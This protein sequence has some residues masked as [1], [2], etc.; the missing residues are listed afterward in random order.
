MINVNTGLCD[1]CGICAAVCPLGVLSITAGA[2]VAPED[3]KARCV[4]CGHCEAVC[5]RG[6]INITGQ[7][8]ADAPH[9]QS[10]RGVSA[11]MIR[12]YFLSRRSIRKYKPEAVSKEAL[13]NVLDI[14]RYAPSAVNAQPVKWV[15]LYDAAKLNEITKAV[16][17]WMESAVSAKH[18]LAEPLNFRGLIIGWKKGLDPITRHAPHVIV[19]CG[20]KDD[21]RAPADATIALTHLELLA[22]AFGLGACWAGYFQIAASQSAEVRRAIGITEDQIPL[23]SMLIGYPKYKYQRVPKRNKLSAIWR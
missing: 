2:L 23:G 11:E 5:P 22:P 4:S 20:L 13:E 10:T 7:L 19:A 17:A 1:N 12:D 21:R 9:L 18:P 6:A 16:V 8:L 14:V 3:R 15:V